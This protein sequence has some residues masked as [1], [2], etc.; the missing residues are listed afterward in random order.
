MQ[1]PLPA[2]PIRACGYSLREGSPEFDDL[3]LSLDEAEALGV[4][5]VELPV[6]AWH[7]VIGG[8]VLTDRLADLSRA[9]AGRRLGYSVHGPL[10]INLMD[11]PERLPRHEAVLEASI[12]V[13]GTIG[14]DHLVIHTGVVREPGD[15]IEVAYARQREA[16]AGIGDKAAAAGITLCVENIFRFVGARETASPL[17]LAGEIAA[18]DHEAVRATLDVS[19]AYIRCAETRHDPLAEI[20]ELAPYVAHLHLHDS[21]GRPKE[22]WT[23]D[24]AEAAA[25]GEGDLHLPIGWGSIDWAAVA[26]AAPLASGTVAILE[27]NPRHWR[28]IGAQIPALRAVAARFRGLDAAVAA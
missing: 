1:M 18:I 25:F 15:D 6:Y 8:R 21:F 3:G 22:L 11:L 28:E 5:V 13:A 23:Y 26:A 2:S 10:A 16:L 19:H 27:L 17:K 9:L 4:D 24:P 7:L 20:A 12:E 14:A